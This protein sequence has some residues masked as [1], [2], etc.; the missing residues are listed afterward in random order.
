[1][2]GLD[3][4]PAGLQTIMVT[5]GQNTPTIAYTATLAGQP[6]SVA[7]SV[8]RGDLGSAVAGPASSTIVTPTG[9]TG[10][11]LTVSARLGTTTIKR[12]VFIQLDGG[13]QNGAS[14]NPLEQQQTATTVAQ[15]G[16]GGGIGGVGGEG[17]GG[18]V[19]ASTLTALATPAGNGS[20]QMLSFLYPYDATVWP[21]GMLAPL[22]MWNWSQG[23][24][25]AIQIELLTTSGSYH[26]KGTF[27]K[28][29]VLGMTGA[30]TTKFI[31]SPIPQDVWATATNTAGGS[32]PNGKPDQLTVKLTVAI[33]GQGFGPVSQTWSVAAARLTGTVYYNSYGT[34]L[35]QN[36]SNI[37][38]TAGHYIGAAILGIRSGDTGPHLVVGATSAPTDDSGCRVCH[39]VSSRGRYLIAQ[40]EQPAAP[41]LDVTSFLYDLN[42]AN[43]QATATQFT[44]NG[45]FAWAAML[46]DASY[47]YTNVIEPSSTNPAI[48]ATTSA[49]YAFGAPPGSGVL[50]AISTGLPTGVGAGYPSFAPDDQYLA[51]VDAT[52]TGT[53]TQNCPMNVAAYDAATQT[54]SNVK[55]IYTPPMG[56][57]AGYPA[58][59][60]DDSGVLF[61]QEVR[62]NGSDT[63]MVTRSGERSQIEW[64][65]LGV[66]PMPVV[67]RNL[68]GIGASGSYLPTGGNQHGLDNTGIEAGYDDTTLDY[69]PTVLPIVAGGYAWVVFTS[70][71]LYGNQCVTEPWASVPTA[72]NLADPSQAPTKKLWVAAIDLNAP[73]GSDPSHPAFYLPAQEL[74][75]G[76]SRGF[77]V[78]DPCKTDGTS[79]ASGDQ[80]CNGYCQPDPTMPASLVC[81]N[82]AMCSNVQE[83]CTTPADCCDT[84]NTCTNGFCAGIPIQ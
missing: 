56:T 57:R 21:R 78:L 52:G 12:Q 43:P 65:K 61:E 49:L 46:S 51:Y 54:F 72:Y 48:S 75:A 35:V 38:D 64:L 62:N 26:W 36:W 50:A 2:N 8:D 19:D 6:V 18:A 29:A 41:N 55:T 69:E 84:T 70:R 31:R 32:T 17:L 74:D 11:M 45:T 24:A 37:Q 68:V 83:K 76:N 20:V 4:E 44:T 33:G 5:L 28:P 10:G 23:D 73:A 66:S 59:L 13:T 3:I 7:W 79:C 80:C 63:V 22:L 71:R 42:D 9:G 53:N 25:D 16:Q 40:A 1:M 47:A 27:A 77:W 30:P 81:S 60:P 15:L 14:M 82:T 67:L 34:Q 39:V 58:F